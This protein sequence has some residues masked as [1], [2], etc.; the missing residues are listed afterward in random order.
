MLVFQNYHLYLLLCFTC[1]YV[2]DLVVMLLLLS[3]SSNHCGFF[4]SKT[5]NFQRLLQVN[6]QCIVFSFVRAL[7]VPMSGY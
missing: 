6:A 5:L 1:H 3:L 4:P 2:E 7:Q